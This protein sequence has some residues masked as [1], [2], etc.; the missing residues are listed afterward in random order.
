ME[1]LWMRFRLVDANQLA[2]RTFKVT[3]LKLWRQTKETDRVVRQSIP[4]NLVGFH[5]FVRL[6][7]A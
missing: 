7:T 2:I 3:S 4:L 1:F 5:C 6:M